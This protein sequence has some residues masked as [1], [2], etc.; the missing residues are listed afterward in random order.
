MVVERCSIRLDERPGGVKLSA[1]VGMENMSPQPRLGLIALAGTMFL[2]PPSLAQSRMS[3]DLDSDGKIGR[4]EF[5]SARVKQIMR[6]DS[7][8][9]GGV[10]RAE[11]RTAERLARAL[12]GTAAVARL[13]ALWRDADLDRDGAITRAEAAGIADRRFALYDRNG[14][15][16]LTG[17]EIS[18]AQRGDPDRK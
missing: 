4:A 5:Q 3:L 10:V 14:D 12:G 6:M 1:F 11:S 16:V 15:G 7:D 2:A 9:D 8:R 17:L 13:E 18:A